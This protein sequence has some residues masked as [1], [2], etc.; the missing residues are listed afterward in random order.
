MAMKRTS[1]LM[2]IL[3]SMRQFSLAWSLRRLHCPVTNSALVLEVGSGGNPYFRSNVLLDAYEES[4]E[5][6]FAPLISDRPTALGF[7]EHLPFPDK[8]F[9][10]VIASHV[11]EHSSD[12]VRFL[13]ELQRV[14]K[15]GYIEAPD[16]FMERINPYRDHR[17]EIT[18][19]NNRLLIRKKEGSTIDPELV[20]LYEAQVKSFL[21]NETMRQ[22]P[23]DFHVRYYWEDT[24]DYEVIN[25][26]VDAGWHAPE[27]AGSSLLKASLRQRIGHTVLRFIRAFF[28]Q[29]RRNANLSLSELLA[30]PS[31][32]STD[33]TFSKKLITCQEC[34]RTYSVR[35]GI[36]VMNVSAN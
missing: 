35:N 13:S 4:R 11:L 21:T 15:A 5:R 18:V 7:V 22:H 19:R 26:E 28:S 30:C 25:P 10:F 36:P 33:L 34:G 32:R 16:A 6:F 1:V 31:C 24:I 14:A 9:D 20:E 27:G 2:D 12:P 8:S 29:H 3:M 23:F 17:L